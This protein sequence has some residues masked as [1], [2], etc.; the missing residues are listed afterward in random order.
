MRL[1][2]FAEGGP[3]GL[4]DEAMEDSLGI[5]T[6]RW[7]QVTGCAFGFAIGRAAPDATP[8]WGEV[9]DRHHLLW[10]SDSPD[11][12]QELTFTNPETTIGLTAVRY[13]CPTADSPRTIYDADIA[14]N[15]TGPQWQ[16]DGL[17]CW[18]LDHVLTHEL[19]HALGLGHACGA[20]DTLLMVAEANPEFQPQTLFDDDRDG[21]RALY[22]EQEQAPDMPDEG[23]PEPTPE[24]A[25]APDGPQ[26]DVAADGG[27]PGEDCAG[28]D[29]PRPAL[30]LTGLAMAALMAW[31]L[32]TCR[33]PLR[34]LPSAL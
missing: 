13:F 8:A 3:V 1:T 7:N 27:R 24:S 22:P 12:W 19:G 34:R 10:V 26:S 2:W 9:D 31:R 18:N 29:A 32:R 6:E 11:N 33:A 30:P 20:C 5:A 16:C 14:L 15:N 17:G 25:E 21:C 4:S 23:A 28:G